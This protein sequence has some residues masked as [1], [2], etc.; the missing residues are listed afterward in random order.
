MTLTLMTLT[1]MILTQMILTGEGRLRRGRTPAR[2][3]G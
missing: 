1:V 3:A 2:P